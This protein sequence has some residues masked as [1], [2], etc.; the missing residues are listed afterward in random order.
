MPSAFDEFS[1]KAHRNYKGV[2]DEAY[3]NSMFL[4]E[5]MEK[6]GFIGLPTEWWHFDLIGW[7]NFSPIE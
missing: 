2:S 4:Q 3:R 6:H 5:I 1:E 7:E